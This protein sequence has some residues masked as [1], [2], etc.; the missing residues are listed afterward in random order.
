MAAAQ[1]ILERVGTSKDIHGFE[2]ELD[3]SKSKN[4]GD[5]MEWANNLINNS[6]SYKKL[7][8]FEIECDSFFKRLAES[9]DAISKREMDHP[10]PSTGRLSSTFFEAFTIAQLD[11]FNTHA[12]GLNHNLLQKESNFAMAFFSKTFSEELSKDYQEFLTQDQKL[13]NLKNLLD[14]AEKHKVADSLVQNL[15]H[16]IMTLTIKLDQF[17]EDLFKKYLKAPL[18]KNQHLKKE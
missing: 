2:N 3:W 14:Y 4:I 12:K 18:E 16:E 5:A 13:D 6:S 11:K 7:E 10:A 8:F 15:L 9:Y 1:N 17:D